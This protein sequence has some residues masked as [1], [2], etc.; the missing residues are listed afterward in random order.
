LW[1]H[2]LKVAQLLRSAA[3]LYTNQSRSY[4]NLLVPGSC[5]NGNE[6]SGSIKRNKISGSIK[7]KEISGSIKR[8]EISGSIK[9]KEISG[10]IKRKEISWLAEKLCVSQGTCLMVYLVS[11]AI[12]KEASGQ[13]SVYL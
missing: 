3:C 6:I 7:R 8:K 10:S 9:R 5:D 2:S 4:L 1:F 12:Y 11:T 13:H